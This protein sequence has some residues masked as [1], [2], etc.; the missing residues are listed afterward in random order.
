MMIFG[1][2]IENTTEKPD[3]FAFTKLL[4]KY[5]L[6]NGLSP[7]VQIALLFNSPFLSL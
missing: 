1:K 3:F 6:N 5:K 4:L 7:F 2:F